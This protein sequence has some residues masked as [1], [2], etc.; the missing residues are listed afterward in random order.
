MRF[1]GDARRELAAMRPFDRGAVARAIENIAQSPL[2]AGRL[3]KPLH[4]VLF[5]GEQVWQRRAG[6]RRIHYVVREATVTV[7]VVRIRPKGRK[8]TEETL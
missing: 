5:E 6:D 7:V 8:T 1:T 4:D 2:A 3:Q